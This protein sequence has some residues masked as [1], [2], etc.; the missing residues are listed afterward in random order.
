MI[1]VARVRLI[2]LAAVGP[3]FSRASMNKW[4]FGSSSRP[5]PLKWIACCGRGAT[6]RGAPPVRSRASSRTFART[7]TR[8]SGSTPRSSMGCLARS[9][10][11]APNGSTRRGRR[12]QLCGRRC[13]GRTAHRRRR[14]R[15]AAEGPAC[16]RR[17]RRQRRAAGAAAGARRLLRARRPLS[18]AVIAA[19]DGRSGAR[20]R[21]ERDHR[22]VSASG[23]GRDG[24][25]G[26]GRR[27]AAVS[28]RRRA[29]H[30]RPRLR[31]GIDP[32]GRS[33]R[34]PRQQ[35]RGARKELRLG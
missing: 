21:R 35:I 28:A 25:R 31:H 15:A 3:D 26:N 13:G 17:A 2:G 22:H 24:G 23:A 32:E 12:R 10:F 4:P 33:H 18:A 19:D 34:R 14:Q 1:R 7:A 6:T 30:R 16:P 5:T 8:R 27:D 29:R 20:R 9:R 11:R